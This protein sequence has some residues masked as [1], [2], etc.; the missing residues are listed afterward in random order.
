MSSAIDKDQVS[1]QR[2]SRQE[3][4]IA[5]IELHPNARSLIEELTLDF[6][7]ALLLQS[8]I[9]AHQ[10]RDDFV[11]RSHVLEGLDVIHLQRREA[12][13]RT[14]VTV[15]GGVL[16]GAGARGFITELQGSRHPTIILIY[17]IL[18]FI[19]LLMALYPMSRR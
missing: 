11:L 12:W 6:G 18:A 2:L 13:W 10:R 7:S 8:K 9:I 1:G 16:F 3:E 14:F 4:E 15:L 17:V 19:G 5:T